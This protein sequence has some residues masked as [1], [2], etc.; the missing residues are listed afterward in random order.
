LQKPRSTEIQ[1]I[2][3]KSKNPT[4]KVV[5]YTKSKKITQTDNKLAKKKP[6]WQEKYVIGI[7]ILSEKLVVLGCFTS[8]GV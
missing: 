4:E 5:A 8:N 1:T 6:K 2:A 3:K 7:N